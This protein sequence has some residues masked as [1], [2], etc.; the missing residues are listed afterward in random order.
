M[1]LKLFVTES[2]KRIKTKILRI[3]IRIFWRFRC[4][5]QVIH[6]YF[7][8]FYFFYSRTLFWH[9]IALNAC[10]DNPQ[11]FCL[12]YTQINFDPHFSV[13]F[14]SKV[15]NLWKTDVIINMFNIDWLF[16]SSQYHH[17]G[18]WFKFTWNWIYQPIL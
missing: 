3:W 7:C 6:F 18:W 17:A 5:E 10:Y 8:S 13:Y 9:G 1:C 2:L 16:L 12:D 15:Y 14:S 11:E 4:R